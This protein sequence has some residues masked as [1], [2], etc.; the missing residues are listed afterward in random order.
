MPEVA[1]TDIYVE[2]DLCIGAAYCVK[3]ASDT[4]ALDDEDI[5]IVTDPAGSTKEELA[6]AADSCPA[7]AIYLD[8]V[9]SGRE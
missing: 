3:I 6:E 5:A 4:F 2:R 7:G 9:P 1:A 8:G